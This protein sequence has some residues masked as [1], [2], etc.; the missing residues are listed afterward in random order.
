VTPGARIYELVGC[1]NCLLQGICT[2]V[3]RVIFRLS[4][5]CELAPTAIGV[6]ALS[7]DAGT[8]QYGGRGSWMCVQ[9]EGLRAMLASRG[10]RNTD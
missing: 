7:F 5:F 6:V 8:M 9:A 3:E 2:P 1:P 4:S 10:G